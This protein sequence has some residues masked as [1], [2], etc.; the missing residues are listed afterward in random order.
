MCSLPWEKR[1]GLP[2]GIDSADLFVEDTLFGYFPSAECGQR[3][4]AVALNPSQTD[5]H[6]PLTFSG[7]SYVDVDEDAKFVLGR[8][9]ATV[10]ECRGMCD[11]LAFAMGALFPRTR[12]GE[13]G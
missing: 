7:V 8:T 5:F 11:S 9:G 13:Q 2:L 10:T 3:S 12:W 1:Y 6:P 4:A